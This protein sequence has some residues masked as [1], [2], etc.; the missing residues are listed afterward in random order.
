M[1]NP[2]DTDYQ[3]RGA[4]WAGPPDIPLID[5]S[6]VILETGCGNGKTL[7]PLIAAGYRAVGID[8]AREAVRLA[9]GLHALVGDIRALPFADGRFDAVFCR[10]V[11]GHLAADDRMHAAAELLLVLAPGGT[12]YFSAFSRADFRYGR[13]TEIEPHSFLKGDGIMTHYFTEDELRCCFSAGEISVEEERWGLRVRGT[14]YP[15]SELRA[16]VRKAEE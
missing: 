2:F 13:G 6:A 12:L 11:L 8:I 10:H 1:P 7:Q 3:V 5:K 15:R 14:V 16:V 4:R 9:G